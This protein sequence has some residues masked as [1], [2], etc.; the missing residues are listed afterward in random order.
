[1]GFAEDE[2]RLFHCLSDDMHFHFVVVGIENVD[3]T[4]FDRDFGHG[5]DGQC[6]SAAEFAG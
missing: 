3:V 5:V 2:F 6:G 4:A 1:M